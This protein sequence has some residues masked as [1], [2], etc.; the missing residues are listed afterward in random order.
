[1]T[2]D[3]CSIGLPRDPAIDSVRSPFIIRRPLV[4]CRRI[5]SLDKGGAVARPHKRRR[6]MFAFLAVAGLALSCAWVMAQDLL[7]LSFQVPGDSKPIV[8]SADTIATWTQGGQRVVL[9]RGKVLVEHGVLH[10]R[11]HEAV[12]WVDQEGYRRT[13]I[14]RVE[15]YAEGDV[16]LENSTDV[17]ANPKALVDL[18]TRGEIKLRSKDA[19]V[20]QEPQLSDP[21][22]LRAAAA[23]SGKQAAANEPKVRASGQELPAA[24]SAG[25]PD[26]VT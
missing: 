2:H 8:M 26:Q 5:G 15:I 4:A 23:R 10:Q 17:K 11:M 7:R 20:V 18:S 16:K 19:K 9:L 13:G 21:L 25:P 6:L 3:H 24:A 12:V 14:L 1:M 22:Y